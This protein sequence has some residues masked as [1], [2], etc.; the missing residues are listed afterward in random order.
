[1]RLLLAIIFLLNIWSCSSQAD[2]SEF[3]IGQMLVQFR[4]A[5]DQKE[6]LKFYKN[7]KALFWNTVLKDDEDRFK[8]LE[9]S[10][11]EQNLPE[12]FIRNA[13]QQIK[14]YS[15][16]HRTNT[17][18]RDTFYRGGVACLNS[19][20]YDEIPK[21]EKQIQSFSEKILPQLDSKSLR[22]LKALHKAQISIIDKRQKNFYEMESLTLGEIG[23]NI[24]DYNVLSFD[25]IKRVHC[26]EY[27]RNVKENI[28]E[29]SNTV[30]KQHPK[31][32]LIL[33]EYSPLEKELVEKINDENCKKR[34][35]ILRH[36]DGLDQ[37]G[38]KQTQQANLLLNIANQLN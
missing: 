5:D 21:F 6:I 37:N 3:E 31:F 16:Q 38:I 10:M 24:T 32:N 29:F 22:K 8:K 20:L 23:K 19:F 18:K 25:L 30:F 35:G 28:Y 17:I 12:E 7:D 2:R 27:D 11:V 4:N 14:S 1:M 26:S 33:D 13:M 9:S 36:Y 34:I 15:A